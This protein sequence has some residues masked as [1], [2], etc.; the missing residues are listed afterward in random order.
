MI[1][2]QLV[3]TSIGGNWALRQMIE[4]VKLGVEVHVAL[5]TDGPL[6]NQYVE[7]GIRVHELNYSLKNIFRSAKGLRRIVHE[8]SPR[9]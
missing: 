1:V 4:L 6:I 3:K 2:L 9:G 5:P 7:N 8:V